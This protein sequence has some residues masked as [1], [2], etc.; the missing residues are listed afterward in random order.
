MTLTASSTPIW[1][2]P[3]WLETFVVTAAPD[4]KRWHG[5]STHTTGRGMQD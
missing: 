3:N 4:W 1:I 5:T 2:N